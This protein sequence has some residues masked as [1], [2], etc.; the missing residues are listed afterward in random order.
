VRI[1]EIKEAPPP[2]KEDRDLGQ[3]ILSTRH[4]RIFFRKLEGQN[5]VCLFGL[6]GRRGLSDLGALPGR[7][8]LLRP[9]DGGGLPER[10][11]SQVLAVPLLHQE[12]LDLVK[13]G[14]GARLHLGA[15][16]GLAGPVGARRLLD[17]QGKSL[18]EGGDAHAL[19]GQVAVVPLAVLVGDVQGVGGKGLGGAAQL[20]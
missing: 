7:Q 17:G 12:A 18:V 2:L 9:D 1:E 3:A 13:R 10:G 6:L 14:A 8:R 5:R 15:D 20:Q 11:L 4:Y 19:A 16:E